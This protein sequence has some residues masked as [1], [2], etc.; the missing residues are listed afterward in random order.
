MATSLEKL[1]VFVVFVFK[2]LWTSCK[3]IFLKIT[4]RSCFWWKWNV[5]PKLQM[6]KKK[7]KSLP[8][9]FCH[10]FVSCNNG[11]L[12]SPGACGLWGWLWLPQC[13]FQL[14]DRTF[15]LVCSGINKATSSANSTEH[16]PNKNGGPGII[17]FWGKK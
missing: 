10:T 9:F 13:F 17:E 12:A 3:K 14:L 8:G 11:S 5:Y 6:E 15:K 7:L 16:A 1:P 2:F 4:L